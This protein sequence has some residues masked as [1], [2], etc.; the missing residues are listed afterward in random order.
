DGAIQLL[1]AAYGIDLTFQAPQ[2]NFKHFLSLLPHAYTADYAEVEA[3]GQLDLSGFVKGTLDLDR[4]TY[5]AFGI[6]LGIQN[7]AF[8]YPDLPLGIQDIATRTKINSPSSDFDQITVDVPQFKL[9]LGDHPFEGRFKLQTP[10]SDPDIDTQIKG[11][12]DLAEFSKA[13][14]ME[15]IGELS[16]RINTDLTAVA[17]LSD[18]DGGNYEDVNMA[19]KIQVDGFNYQAPDLPKVVVRTLDLDF[20]P[21]RVVVDNLDLKMGNSDLRGSG[22][23]DNILA[24]F[25]PDKTMRGDFKMRSQ[26]FDSNEWLEDGAE[27]DEPS[28]AET[29]ATTAT[30]EET[31]AEETAVFDRFDFRLDAEIDRLLYDIYEIRESAL[32]GRVTPS[33][34]NI[35]RFRML[36]GPS[37][38]AG[39]GRITNIFNYLYGNGT[40]GGQIAL[41]SKLF[42]LNP[43]MEEG[44][45]GEAEAKAIAE[46][47]NLEPFIVPENIDLTIYADVD[48]VLYTDLTLRDLEGTLKVADQAIRF[49]Y[50]EAR[51]LGGLMRIDGGYDTK[52][53]N[54]PGFDLQYAI[55]RFD[56]QE[57]FKKFNTFAQLAPIA[58]F[59]EGT[60]SSRMSFAGTL[61]ENLSPVFDDINAD[62]FL[63]TINGVVRNFAPLEKIGNQ[64]NIDL[65]RK[66]EIKDTKNWFEIKDGK[67][68]VKEFPLQQQGIDML[69]GGSHGPNQDMD[70]QIKAKIPRELLDKAGIGQAADKGLNF[71]KSEAGKVGLNIDVGEFINVLINLTGNMEDPK[72]KFKVLGA[73]GEKSLVEQ[74]KEEVKAIAEEKVEE[75]KEEVVE[76]VEEQKEDLKAK[77]DAEIK[78]IMDAAEK[79]AQRI[80]DGGKQAA[81]EVRKQAKQQS[82]KLIKEA[83]S[84][85]L[86]KRLAEA[87]AKKI[88]QKADKE[89]TKLEQEANQKADQVMSKARQQADQVAITLAHLIG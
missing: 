59:I 42:D 55:K 14:P 46:E 68:V 22:S 47:E 64:L 60:F 67:V 32:V 62:G 18:V 81:D 77:M 25:S 8:Q 21:R 84:N 27:G 71:L 33:E 69:I 10:I 57:T 34:A 2:N 6:D 83:G 19:G 82:D 40:L 31:T 53:P 9:K 56:F 30:T 72:V 87:T 65:F 74:A 26:F 79:Q 39:S 49:E 4:G 88:R 43:F 75:V 12:I 38:L 45:G 37:D 58:K 48:R 13:F 15:E 78:G 61:D 41:R 36:L 76:K 16:G 28:V 3:T 70:Y 7:G 73:G 63:Q 85:A 23:I 1:D 24:Y 89:A 29:T 35:D 50:C 17:R 44:E 66:F 5:P 11:L 86:K 80:R 20:N 52:D 54:K 51:T